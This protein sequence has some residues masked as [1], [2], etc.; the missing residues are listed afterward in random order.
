ML[1]PY[2]FRYRASRR[3]TFLHGKAEQEK[4]YF[5]GM[6]AQVRIRQ[7]RCSHPGDRQPGQR[8]LS[9]RC[10]MQIPQFIPQGAMRCA[11]M[12]FPFMI[13]FFFKRLIND[14]EVIRRIGPARN[15]SAGFFSLE[16][17]DP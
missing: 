15:R 12:L 1:M 7:F 9:R 13:L 8:F 17:P 4:Q 16:R 10:A 6:S 5:P 2:F 14:L 3:C 11:F